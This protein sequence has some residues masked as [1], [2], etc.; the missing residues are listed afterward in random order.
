MAIL[1]AGA[2]GTI[3]SQVLSFLDPKAVE[4]RALTR[5][6]ETARFPAGITAVKGDLSDVDGFKAALQGVSTLFLLGPNVAD[7]STQVL[8]ALNAARDA[9]V[10]GV[11]YLSVFNAN[12]YADLP[13][14]ASKA[15]VERM[16]E[17]FDLPVT[18][19]RAAYF[20][21]NDIRLKDALLTHGV[22]GMP[23]GGKGISM[24]D[25][26]DIGEAAAKELMR[27]EAADGPLPREAYHLVG[28]D[29][30]TGDDLA[31]LWSEV[32]A[33][34]IAYGGNDLEALEQNLKAFAPAWY[35]YDLKLMMRRYQQQGALAS[36]DQIQR[37][38][39]LLGH[40]PRSYRAFAEEVA[41][42]WN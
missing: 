35:A 19:L 16:V 36:A 41:A 14:F 15:A 37:L 29:A 2:S 26:R 18:L 8:L 39:R 10:K 24:V 5:S 28:P 4:V 23:I 42:S 3:G 21:Q 40:A 17:A 31:T 11:V 25:I 33:R 34:P 38:E 6:P 32:L 30:L 13:H 1:V 20:A 9:G 7:E 12:D 27:R 22:Y